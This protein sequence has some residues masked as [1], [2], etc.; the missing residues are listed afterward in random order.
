MNRCIH[1][2]C[3]LGLLAALPLGALA[4]TSPTTQQM[5]D[6]TGTVVV[7]VRSFPP[8]ALRGTLQVVAPPEVLLDSKVARLSP[9]ARIRGANGMLAMSSSLVGQT[10]PV[11][12]LLEPQGMLHEV[13]VLTEVEAAL[14]PTAPAYSTQ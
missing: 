4:Q 3:A 12:Y 13:W 10:V 5:T 6:S 9:G 8:K 14:M 1:T 7:A 11:V 2:L